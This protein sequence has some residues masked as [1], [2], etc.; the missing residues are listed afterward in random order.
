[1]VR[2]VLAGTHVVVDAAGKSFGRGAHVH[3]RPDCVGKACKGGLSRSFKT[4]VEADPAALAAEI[5][6]A[7]DRRIAGLL[8]TARR[9]GA[10]AVGADAALA[11]LGEGRSGGGAGAPPTQLL[12]LACDAGTVAQKD[13]VASAVKSGRAVAWKEKGFLGSLLGHT[14]VAL[15]VVLNGGLAE[16]IKTAR[17]TA[18]SLGSIACRS[19]EVR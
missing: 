7:C 8:V 19:R 3:P 12:V 11:A 2:L 4:R 15:C 1:M 18:D 14:E 10:L 5:V 13:E 17:A 6:E 9:I 16:A